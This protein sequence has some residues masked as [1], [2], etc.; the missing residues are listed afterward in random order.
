MEKLNKAFYQR[1]DVVRV[2]YELLGKLIVTKWNGELT[3]GR[4][5][6]TEAY[7][8]IADK[9]SHAYGGRR[10]VRTEIM[11]APGGV[12][13]VYLCYGMHH[14]FNVVTGSRDEPHAVLLR[15]IEPVEGITVML[16][17]TGKTQ[18]DFSLGAGPGNTSRALGINTSHNGLSLLGAS[19]FIADDGFELTANNILAT[20]RIGVDYAGEN[21]LLPYRFIIRDNLWVSRKKAFT[22]IKKI[23]D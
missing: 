17:R 12:A 16:N 3:A 5:V 23:T 20:P 1:N 2:A 18:P 11:Y 19:I 21:A 6:E 22:A 8:G 14:L 7:K 13:Y 4:I 15:A 9:A 10:T